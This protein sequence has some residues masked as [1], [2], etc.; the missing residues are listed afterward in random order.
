M[1]QTLQPALEELYLAQG[2]TAKKAEE[3]AKADMEKLDTDETFL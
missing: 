1:N 3:L 2:Y